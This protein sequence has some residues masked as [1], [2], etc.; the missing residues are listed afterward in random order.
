[1]KKTLEILNELREKGLIENFA[2]GGGIATIFFTEPAFTYDLDVFII[3]KAGSYEKIIS[4]T[5][6]Y[7]FL[8]SKGYTW[9]GE[10][11]VI[12]DM[13]VQFIPAASNLE[14]EAIENALGVTYSDVKTRVIPAEYLIAIALKAGRAKDF[15]KVARLFEQ[16]KIDKE[17]LKEVLRKYHLLD[18]FKKWKEKLR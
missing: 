18:K 16:A 7:N 17:S 2:V 3:V 5:P 12:E 15:E 4:L 9:K 14:K 8:R 1:M 6:I 11:I 10:H 13:P